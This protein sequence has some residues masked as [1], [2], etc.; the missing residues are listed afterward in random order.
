MESMTVVI[1]LDDQKK[2]RCGNN[3]VA[4]NLGVA[5]KHTTVVI[6]WRRSNMQSELEKLVGHMSQ[7]TYQRLHCD[8][9]GDK[10]KFSWRSAWRRLTCRMI[11]VRLRTNFC[12][13]RRF[14]NIHVNWF[15]LAIFKFIQTGSSWSE[16]RN[17]KYIKVKWLVR[18]N[19][20]EYVVLVVFIYVSHLLGDGKKCCGNK[21]VE[22]SA[23]NIC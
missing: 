19:M 8:R 22:N 23:V 14:W 5:C 20:R 2:Q 1:H 16:G 15:L 9:E 4:K 3:E 17:D 11:V 21:A 7:R 13:K 18:K 6:K 12:N 10:E